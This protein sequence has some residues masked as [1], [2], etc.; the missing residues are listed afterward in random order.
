MSSLV[1]LKK[2]RS[3]VAGIKY[4]NTEGK[5]AEGKVW[6]GTSY[7][8]VGKR[9]GLGSMI[10]SE[11][12][13]NIKKQQRKQGDGYI[14][15]A[16]VDKGG[17]KVPTYINEHG[18]IFHS[19]EDNVI[20][21]IDEGYMKIQKA[22][23]DQQDRYIEQ[24]LE[25]ALTSDEEASNMCN[26]DPTDFQQI[27]A[28]GGGQELGLPPACAK[29]QCNPDFLDYLSPTDPLFYGGIAK[30]RSI[31]KLRMPILKSESETGTTKAYVES[32][33]E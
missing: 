22:K 26:L 12:E 18:M 25:L 29:F 8:A 14:R 23:K 24:M 17:A 10:D 33:K 28:P 5:D 6:F 31:V 19:N 13:E 21:Y 32:N 16:K 27:C 2:G 9:T 1:T 30:L 11:L 3:D 20:S 15:I 7:N 4:R